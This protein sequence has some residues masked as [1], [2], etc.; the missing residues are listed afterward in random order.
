MHCNLRPL[1]VTPVYFRFYYDAMPSL[2]SPNLSIVILQ[3]FCCWYITLRSDLEFWPLTFNICNVSPVTW[4]NSLPN[5]NAI[6]QSV[7]ELLRCQYLTLWPWTCVT[8]CARLWDNFHKV[9]PSTTYP[10]LSV[11][12][13]DTLCH[14]LTLTFDPLTLIVH[15]TV[16]KRHVIKV[17][18]KFERNRAIRGWVINDFAIFLYMLCCAVTL[19]FDLLNLN[20]Y[21]TSKVMCLNSVQNTR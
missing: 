6:D 3:R 18:T 21:G 5:L 7:A 14:V 12:Y 11:F 17:C 19:T 15:G 13:A 16:L 2:K 1:D 8:Y 9:W 10:Y 4:W 20:F